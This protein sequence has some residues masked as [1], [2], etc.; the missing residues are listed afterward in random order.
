MQLSFLFYFDNDN[1]THNYLQI[2]NYILLSSSSHSESQSSVHLAPHNN[3]KSS[4]DT[5]VIANKCW[6]PVS[7]SSSRIGSR[8]WKGSMGGSFEDPSFTASAIPAAFYPMSMI[9]FPYVKLNTSIMTRTFWCAW[10]LRDSLFFTAYGM[11]IYFK[12]FR[13]SLV[14]EKCFGS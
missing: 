3:S 11:M 6:L 14:F 7:L 4:C 13:D 8:S 2:Y 12:N 1:I 9:S 5:S 10:H